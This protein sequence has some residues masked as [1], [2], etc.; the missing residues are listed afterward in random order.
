MDGA[1]TEHQ[2]KVLIIGAT[3]WPENLDEAAWRRFVRRLYIPLP[4]INSREKLINHLISKEWL[5]NFHI[6]LKA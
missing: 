1:R 3:N 6:I 2:D 5:L 4:N